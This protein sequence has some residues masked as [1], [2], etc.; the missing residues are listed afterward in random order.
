MSPQA[1]L[2]KLIPLLREALAQHGDPADPR[3]AATATIIDVLELSAEHLHTRDPLHELSVLHALD[4]T[5][6]GLN[7]VHLADPDLHG[8]RTSELHDTPRRLLAQ[9]VE[10]GALDEERL[11]AGLT[12]TQLD[13]LL[14]ALP[15]PP[16]ER[17]PFGRAYHASREATA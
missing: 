14:G 15:K 9:L 5:H 17:T 13:A 1:E 8:E 4:A 10:R 7:F 11:L 16:K 12:L 2:R 6:A 3:R